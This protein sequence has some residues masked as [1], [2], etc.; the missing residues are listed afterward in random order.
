M[1]KEFPKRAIHLDFHTMPGVY[2]VG[3]EFHPKEFVKTLKNAGVD[4][5]TVFARCN[6]GFAYY[7][8]RIGIIHPGMKK[9]DLLGPMVTE[10]HREGIRVTAYFNAGLSHEEALN[11][12]E[13]CIVNKEGQVVEVQNMGHFFRRMCLNTGYRQ[14][15]LAMVNEVMEMYP[16]DGI[17]LDCFN[18]NACYGVECIDGMKK[19]GMDV[20]DERQAEEYR[21]RITESFMKEVEKLVKVKNKDAYIYFN[22]LPYAK[23]PTHIELEVLPT[24]GWGYDILPMAIRY[25]RTLDKPYF[26]MT[27]RFHKSWGDF[28]GLR[29]EHSL[30]FD[31]YNS[32]ANC[33]TCSVGD[34]MHPRG[35]LEKAVYDL[36]GRVYSKTKELDPFTEGA[37]SMTEMAVIEPAFSMYPA[38]LHFDRSS[39]AGAARMLMELKCQFDVSSGTGDISRYRIIVLPDSVSVDNALKKKLQAHLKKGGFIISSAYAG[40]DVEKKKFA[41][42]EYKISFNGP[43]EYNYTFFKAEKEVSEGIQDMLTTI[44]EPGISMQAEKGA[45]A[46]RQN[47]KSLTSRVAQEKF[48]VKV[49]ARIFKPYFNLHSWDWRHENLYIPPEKDAGRPALVRCGNIFHFSFPVFKGYFNDAVVAYKTLVKNCLETAYPEP[50]VQHK[51]IPSF[52]QVTVTEQKNR[53]IIHILS[54]IPELRGKTQIIEEPVVLK[55]ISLGLRTDGKKVGKVYLAPSGEELGFKVEKNYIWITLSE[56]KGYQMVVFEM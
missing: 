47:H 12:R 43:E 28:C 46:E 9:K 21:W 10:C 20:F 29:P 15:L 44:Y 38:L 41:L 55:N 42:D 50:L 51:N 25:A 1:K 4:Y 27:G 31:L 14:H 36:I 34:H 11:H 35:K 56:V 37:V 52:A 3:A 54:Y 6:L 17:F 22:G 13:W 49:L 18:L 7:P 16:V 2:D 33:G 48:G 8:T 53:R 32:I 5:I 40:V 26:T 24:G 19:L 45:K 39:V 23:Q 30:L